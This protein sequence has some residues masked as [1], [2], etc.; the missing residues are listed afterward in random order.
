MGMTKGL[1]RGLPFCR[2][3]RCAVQ[4]GLGAAACYRPVDSTTAGMDE[5]ILHRVGGSY[6]QG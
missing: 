4:D 2:S 6:F 5:G 1:A 3:A